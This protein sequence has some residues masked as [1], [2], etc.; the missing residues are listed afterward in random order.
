MNIDA[1][2][3]VHIYYLN[4]AKKSASEYHLEFQK[5]GNQLSFDLGSMMNHDGGKNRYLEPE[6]FSMEM[7]LR[8]NLGP[9]HL[10]DGFIDQTLASDFMNIVTNVPK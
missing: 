4:W 5:F 10:L 9:I 7:V 8:F 6:Y 2:T 3:N 1:L